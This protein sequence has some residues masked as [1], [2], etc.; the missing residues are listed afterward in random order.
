MTQPKDKL[1]VAHARPTPINSNTRH[2]EKMNP[3]DRFGFVITRAVGTM[4]AAM[5]FTGLA[6]ISLPA[7]LK[8]HDKIVIVA[9]IAQTFLQL[10]LLPIIMVGQNIQG[11]HTEVMADEEFKTTQT[12]YKDL[13]HLILVNQQQ[14]ELLIALAKK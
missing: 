13:E 6:L 5:L 11:K 4:I 2:Q 7:A 12:T 14:L 3:L 10:V 9:W 1:S 8:T